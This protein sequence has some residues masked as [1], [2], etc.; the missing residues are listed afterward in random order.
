[1]FLVFVAVVLATAGVFHAYVKNL[2]VETA[3]KTYKSDKRTNQ[4]EMDIMTINM[5][6]DEQM[7]R[8]VLR[9]RLVMQGSD[10]VPIPSSGIIEI[11]QQNPTRDP[12]QD[13]AHRVP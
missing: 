1:V 13:L 9:E 10:L 7:N 11:D 12:E 8:Y 2:Q 3:R 4:L 6:L 5:Q